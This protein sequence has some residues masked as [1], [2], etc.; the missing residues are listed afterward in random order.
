MAGSKELEANEKKYNS[1]KYNDTFREK[2]KEELKEKKI[3]DVCNR[4]Y[5]YYTKSKHMKTKKHIKAL[6]PK[7]DNKEQ[8]IAIDN[9]VNYVI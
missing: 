4:F 9:Q 2:H 8:L 1:K 7:Q 6:E 3:C 5:T